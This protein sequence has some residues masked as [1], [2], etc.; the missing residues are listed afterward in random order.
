MICAPTDHVPTE[1]ELRAM[2]HATFPQVGLSL[3]RLIRDPATTARKRRKYFAMLDQVFAAVITDFAPVL[4]T[5]NDG[6]SLSRP[7]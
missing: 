6:K 2:V 3:I 4:R 7:T 1:A 5:I